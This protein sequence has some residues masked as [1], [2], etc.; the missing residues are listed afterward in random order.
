MPGKRGR[1][2]KVI[3]PET[4]ILETPI[5]PVIPSNT[6]D[7]IPLNEH[8]IYEE[9]KEVVEKKTKE[10]KKH[11]HTWVPGRLCLRNQKDTFEVSKYSSA[12]KI[13]IVW[14][15]SNDNCGAIKHTIGHKEE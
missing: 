5:A 9:P 11:V 4:P 15:C 3:A 2:K 13:E 10:E 12:E 6:P 1:P 8:A 7:V 14:V